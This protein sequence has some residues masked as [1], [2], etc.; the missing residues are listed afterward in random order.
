MKSEP[1]RPFSGVDG[2]LA[3]IFMIG[4]VTYILTAL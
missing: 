2:N 1:T 3:I 4:F